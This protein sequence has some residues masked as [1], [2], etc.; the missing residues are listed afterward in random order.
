VTGSNGWDLAIALVPAL[1]AA[2]AWLQSWLNNRIAKSSHALINQRFTDL[3]NVNI[4]L[5]REVSDLRTQRDVAA[6]Q[7]TAI[8]DAAEHAR[9]V[10]ELAAHKAAALIEAKALGTS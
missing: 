9:A 2:G 7:A 3:E 6:G 4:A 1:L 5:R 10:I 8:L